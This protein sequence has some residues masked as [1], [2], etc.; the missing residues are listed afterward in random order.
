MSKNTKH[1]DYKRLLA[2][3]E[4][5][6]EL[7]KAIK[8]LGYVELEKPVHHGY[9]AYLTL[10][11]D[12]A[13]REDRVAGLYQYFI[14][15]FASVPWSRLPEFYTKNKRGKIHDNRPKLRRLT[16]KEYDGYLPWI[17]EHFHKRTKYNWGN[18]YIYY[19]PY[20][21][22]Y[23]LVMK[24]KNSYITHRKVI[25]GDLESE[26]IFIKHKIWGLEDKIKPWNQNGYS[27][28]LKLITKAKRRNDKIALQKNINTDFINDSYDWVIK[29][30]INITERDFITDSDWTN[31]A[32]SSAWSQDF[33]EFNYRARNEA[34][35]FYF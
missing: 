21:P 10:R 23:Y 20:I 15:N 2:L 13:K 1:K 14:D 32:D 25:D 5:E 11:E 17:Q 26:R 9:N 30:G 28:F 35:W 29:E 19:V 34:K 31:W 8:N 33:Y 24:I 18:E 27:K 7:D 4:R 12:V 6:D 22:D 3:R 16:Q